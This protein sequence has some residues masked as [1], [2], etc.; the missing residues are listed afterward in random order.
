MLIN[1][2][3]G[4]WSGD[5]HEK[6]ENILVLSNKSSKEIEKAYQDGTEI[7][8]FDFSEECCSDYEDYEIKEKYIKILK[9]ENIKVDDNFMDIESFASIYIQICKLGDPE[10]KIDIQDIDIVDIGGYGLFS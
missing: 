10:L 4:D 8:G 6:T 9:N 3:V 7:L 5:G 1:L 2:V